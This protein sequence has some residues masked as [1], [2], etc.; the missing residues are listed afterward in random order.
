[1]NYFNITIV[2]LF[3]IG[4]NTVMPA[5]VNS[6][7]DYKFRLGDA[8]FYPQENF[9]D[10]FRNRSEFEQNL[11]GDTYF[12]IMQFKDAPTKNDRYDMRQD[13]TLIESITNHTYIVSFSKKI[14]KKEF[15]K[16]NVR[17]ILPLTKS[18]KL[19][20]G[21]KKMM[22]KKKTMKINVVVGKSI[23]K[24]DLNYALESLNITRST[25]IFKE[26]TNKYMIEADEA[27]MM[28]IAS[29]TNVVRVEVGG[30]R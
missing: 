17:A 19:E 2:A 23:D 7:K 12:V 26:T 15:R 10:F 8:E 4:F 1:M 14:K 20:R 30:L 13:I 16:F 24:K 3:L 9:K 5:E 25:E 28:K 6:E 29:W 11:D 18:M 22:Q 27:Q 21:L